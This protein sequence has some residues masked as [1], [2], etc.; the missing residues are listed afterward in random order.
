MDRARMVAVVVPSPATS[1]V[2]WATALTSLAPMF[3]KGSGSSI[4]FETVTPS[5]GT[6]GPPQRVPTMTFLAVEQ[7]AG[8]DRDNPASLRLLL[9]SVRQQNA[10]RG[11]LFGLEHLD[12]HAVVERTNVE[13]RFFFLRHDW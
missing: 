3:S 13:A 4:S 1:L 6:V 8:A 2:F 11:F 7:L 5:L 12:H 10:A 9:G